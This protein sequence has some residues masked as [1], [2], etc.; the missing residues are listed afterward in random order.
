MRRDFVYLKVKSR[1]YTKNASH[2]IA[3]HHLGMLHI[4]KAVCHQNDTI[5]SSVL[6]AITHGH[7]YIFTT[8]C[9]TQLLKTSLPDF[10]TAS[11]PC[12]ECFLSCPFRW[13]TL[14]RS[15]SSL[16]AI[17]FQRMQQAQLRSMYCLHFQ[18]SSSFLRYNSLTD[19]FW[20]FGRIFVDEHPHCL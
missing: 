7:R 12:L 20:L 5:S 1:G 8:I 4:S 17:A 18:A 3:R 15:S 16:F 11:G 10:L 2:C 6:S 13:A 14:S 9:W 19:L